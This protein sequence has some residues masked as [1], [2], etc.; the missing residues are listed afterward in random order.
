MWLINKIILLDSVDFNKSC[1]NL[2]AKIDDFINC[3]YG[4]ILIS[5]KLRQFSPRNQTISLMSY[6]KTSSKA[7]ILI[8]IQNRNEIVACSM[9]IILHSFLSKP[10][11]V[12]V[13]FVVVVFGFVSTSIVPFKFI[14]F[15]RCATTLSRSNYYYIIMDVHALS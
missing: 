12:L 8:T 3:A 11:E 7:T 6:R 15:V 10:K 4:F 9:A 13:V 5:S 2:M 1:P 14:T